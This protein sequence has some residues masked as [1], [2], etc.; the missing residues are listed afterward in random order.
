M[1]NGVLTIPLSGTIANPS[2]S[3]KAGVVSSECADGA[4]LTEFV[5]GVENALAAT[6]LS[7]LLEGT[8]GS[9]GLLVLYGPHGSGKTHLAR[10]LVDW[11]RKNFSHAQVNCLS[12]SDFARQY[13]EALNDGR[14]EAWRDEIRQADLFVLEDLGELAGKQ[15]AQHEFLHTL[16]ALG[17]REASVVTT[18]RTLP[19]Y[20]SVLVPPLRSRLSAGLA[21]PLVFPSRATRR[22][23]LEQL[24]ERRNLPVPRRALNGLA[25]GLT[26]SVPMLVSAIWEL[27]LAARMTGEPVDP[28][29]VRKLV[30]HR[31]EGAAAKLRD[32]ARL[33]AKH[34]G[35]KLADLKSPERRRA[36]VA[37][38]CVAMYLARQLTSCSLTEI[39]QFF[40]GR[41][42]TTV[43]H[44]CRRTEKLLHHDWSLRQAVTN[45]RKMLDSA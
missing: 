8:L 15:S 21:V 28:L 43:L 24:A 22:A 3:A 32:I 7:P 25:D 40:G 31:D 27:E 23:I 13:V 18:A 36:L 45:I 4:V 35:L 12:G 39:G 30:S 16:D 17:D 9:H 1:V 44:G 14:L 6:A 42:H 34:F 26:G 41:D 11:W 33:T 19:S 37:A 5:A 29:R 20:W 10:G 2:R 38:R